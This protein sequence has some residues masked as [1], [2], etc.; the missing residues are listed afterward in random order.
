MVLNGKD[1]LS[2]LVITTLLPGFV[3]LCSWYFGFFVFL[4]S[5]LM[6]R[7]PGFISVTPYQPGTATSRSKMGNGTQ[8]SKMIETDAWKDTHASHC[9]RMHLFL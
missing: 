5:V 3:S 7:H 6:L 9:M 4:P 8:V 2:Y 1:Q